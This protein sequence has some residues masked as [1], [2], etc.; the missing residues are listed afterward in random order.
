MNAI[1][2]IRKPVVTEKA[3]ILQEKKVYAFW[4]DPRATKIDVKVA[5]KTLYGVDVKAVR[6]INVPDK[7]RAIRKGTMNK[8]KEFCKAYVTLKKDGKLDFTK[9]EKIDAESKVKLAGPKV[10][11]ASKSVKAAQADKKPAKTTKK[12]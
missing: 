12:K 6:M 1:N 5:V 2:V 3:S 7:F 10:S 4:V 9:F 8:R 11:K